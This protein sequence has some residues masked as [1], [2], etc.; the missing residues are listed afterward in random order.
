MTSERTSNSTNATWW[1]HHELTFWSWATLRNADHYLSLSAKSHEALKTLFEKDPTKWTEAR[2]EIDDLKRQT[3]LATY[4]FVTA[5]GV[6]IRVLQRSQHL[7]PSIQ[8]PYS[9]AKHLLK[10]GI[11]IRDMIEHA[12]G[13]D[14][15]LAGGG[16]HKEKFV[17][18]EAG[19]VADATSTIIKDDGH[20][21]GNRL[22]VE[23]VVIELLDINDEVLKLEAP[24][25]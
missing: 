13:K 25:K 23:K 7:F 12:Y 21:L 1:D 5:M 3:A 22:C 10:E 18:Q 4:H 19:I 6:L 14:G 16:R 20:W 17:R 24:L 11:E 9:R 15:Y 8:P 2:A